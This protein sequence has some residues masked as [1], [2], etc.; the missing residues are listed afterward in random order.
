M[1]PF[2][3][4]E[5]DHG[6]AMI[7]VL[8]LLMILTILGFGYIG[9]ANTE[10]LQSF[11]YASR[12]QAYHY[13]KAGAEI[14][15]QRIESDP[16]SMSAFAHGSL[17][18][19]AFTDAEEDLNGHD[20]IEVRLIPDD[21]DNQFVRLRSTG[22]HGRVSQTVSLVML[23]TENKGFQ[24]LFDNALYSYAPID[25]THA[26]SS[27]IGDVESAGSISGEVPGDIDGEVKPS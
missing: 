11:Q 5:N 14:V 10:T 21:V 6:G 2:A 24:G 26:N 4:L 22:R 15:A 8:F 25:A 20:P 16:D 13:A 7:W 18:S 12:L 17:G 27:I 1:G 9:L 23:V 19:L 3:D